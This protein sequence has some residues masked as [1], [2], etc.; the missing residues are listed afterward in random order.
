MNRSEYSANLAMMPHNAA[1]VF[2]TV[3]DNSAPVAPAFIDTRSNYARHAEF[4]AARCVVHHARRVARHNSRPL[5]SWGELSALAVGLA[6]MA[7]SVFA[8]GAL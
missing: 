7:G 2:A 4:Y 1:P 6:I 8:A 3:R 5:K